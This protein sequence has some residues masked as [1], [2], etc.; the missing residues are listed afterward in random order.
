MRHA[1]GKRHIMKGI[2][3]PNK[4]KKTERS[5]QRK[6]VLEDDTIKQMKIKKIKKE[7]LKGSTK[8]L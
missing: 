3:L 1:S 4:E 8:I 6:S 7:Y 2:E 5:E